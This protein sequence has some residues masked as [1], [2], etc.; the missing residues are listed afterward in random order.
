VQGYGAAVPEWD[1]DVV[2][3]EALVRRLLEEQF[4]ELATRTVRFLGKGWDNSVWVVD[5]RWAFRIPRRAI[6]LPG[7]ER[8]LTVLPRAAPLLPVQVPL[9]MLVGAATEIFPWPFFAHRLLPGVEPADADLSDDER[10][11][12]GAQLGRLLRVLHAPETLAAVDPEGVL[13]VDFNLRADM[14][15]RVPRAR[16]NLAALRE[17]GLW[18]APVAVERILAAAEQLPP[19]SGE[20]V[21]VHGDLHLRHVLVADGAIT[22]VIDWGDVCRADPCV[23]LMLVWSLLGRPGRERFYAEYGPVTAEQRLRSRVLAI[24]IHSMLVRY[25]H[26][27]GHASLQQEAV[28]ALGRTLVD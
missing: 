27:A 15:V 28:A 13:P 17:L 8:E 5:D 18:R 12:V 20:I 3:D 4:P 2:V 1:P 16:E 14:A 7:V 9:P 23:D 22:A 11:E 25:A 26:D 10:V 19:A 6:A 24:G 21:L